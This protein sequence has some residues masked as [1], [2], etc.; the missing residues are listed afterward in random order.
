[1]MD[2]RHTISR[3][4]RSSNGFNSVMAGWKFIFGEEDVKLLFSKLRHYTREFLIAHAMRN[5][6]HD[7][8]FLAGESRRWNFGEKL[9]LRSA[10]EVLYVL[11][12]H[13]KIILSF[14]TNR[15]SSRFH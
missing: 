9:L 12:E 7:R 6:F 4:C 3:V 2:A 11:I 15:V 10:Y 13:L 14:S 8:D 5:F 1:M